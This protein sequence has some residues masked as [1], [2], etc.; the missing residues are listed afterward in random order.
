MSPNS[1]LNNYKVANIILIELSNEIVNI[2]EVELGT[3]LDGTFHMRK[4]YLVNTVL[5]CTL[6]IRLADRSMSSFSY[7]ITLS[8][9]TFF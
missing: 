2:K 4:G 7:Q 6:L 3:A 5:I 8:N 1:N 9:N